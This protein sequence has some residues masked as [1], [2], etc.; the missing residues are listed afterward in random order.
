MVWTVSDTAVITMFANE[1]CAD[2][3]RSWPNKLQY[4]LRAQRCSVS[5]ANRRALLTKRSG[6]NLLLCQPCN[7][8]RLLAEC[9][10]IGI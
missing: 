1:R 9:T 2:A 7:M 3:C 10:A 6:L 4:R 8:I 5:C